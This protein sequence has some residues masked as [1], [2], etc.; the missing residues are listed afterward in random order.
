MASK[1]FQAPDTKGRQRVELNR[2]K[3]KVIV[4]MPAYNAEKTLEATHR[5]IP[6]DWVD[7]IILVDDASKDQTVEVARSLGLKV[8]V[9]PKNRGYGGNQKTC[10]AA[11]LEEGADIVVMLHPDHQYDPRLIPEMIKPLQEGKA[12]VVLG[13]RF[14]KDEAIKGGMP[15]W[16]W[17]GNRLLSTIE[18]IALGQSFTEYHTG[19]R[20]YS[21][22]CLETIPFERNSED[23]VFD[24]E[25]VVQALHFGMR[26]AEVAIPARYFL[27][28]SSVNFRHSVIYGLKTLRLLLVYR[29]H[30][31]GFFRC[32]LFEPK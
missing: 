18:N 12:D 19:Y 21:R 30:R 6:M 15:Q 14:L 11:A 17:V 1:G 7:D 4:V 16:K 32:A 8:I 13:S 2:A 24:Q 10:Y 28:A 26:I 3:A 31:A 20:G 5:D 27:E 9:H 23:F 29:L 25:F 22:R